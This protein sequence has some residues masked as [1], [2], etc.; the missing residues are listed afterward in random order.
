MRAT[1]RHQLP[2]KPEAVF[3]FGQSNDLEIFNQYI[4]KTKQYYLNRVNQHNIKRS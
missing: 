3:E 2:D 1:K 4:R